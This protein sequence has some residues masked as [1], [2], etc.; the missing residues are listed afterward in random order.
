M[1][2]HSRCPWSHFLFYMFEVPAI[3]LIQPQGESVPAIRSD[4][5]DD[6]HLQATDLS[7]AVSALILT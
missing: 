5:S 4:S 6:A 3:Q 2:F 7:L 1:S